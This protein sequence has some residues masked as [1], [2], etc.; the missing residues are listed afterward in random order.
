MIFAL[1]LTVGLLGSIWVFGIPLIQA[2]VPSSWTQNKWA[3][4]AFTGAFLLLTVFVASAI[5]KGVGAKSVA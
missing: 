2:Q 5:L 3:Q 4:I 1:L